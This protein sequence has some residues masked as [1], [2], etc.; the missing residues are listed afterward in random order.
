MPKSIL[1]TGASSGI[2]KATALFFAEK[3][4]NV[5]ATM[6]NIRDAED[7]TPIKNILILPLDVT[8]ME[9]IENAFTI[10]T[11]KFGKIDVLLNNAGYAQYGIF[12]S[13]SDKQIRNQFEVNVFGTINVT[14]S[15]L[16]IFR[17]QGEGMI[18]NV[19]SGSG[20]FSVPLMSLYNASKFALEGF[21]ESLAYELAS[22]N[23][24]VKII[25]PGS[26]ASNFHHTLEEST[27]SHS[28]YN[29]YIQHL[30]SRMDIVRKNTSASSSV[31][32]DIAATIFEAA[33]DGAQTL[34][35]VSGKDIQPI[36]DMRTSSSEEEYMRFMRNI[37]S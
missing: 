23:I 25:E 17:T 31:P 19:T 34:R 8:E 28:A 9:S 18:I 20:R 27:V 14:K 3:G 37:F 36:I 30:N 10:G 29:D 5:I 32:D 16:P 35:Y 26:T 33:T 1:I 12:E 11:E 22:Q 21:S 15:I 24:T 7:L 4:W 13:L 2:G 6:R